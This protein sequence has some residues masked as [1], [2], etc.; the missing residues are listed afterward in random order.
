MTDKST[1]TPEEWKLLLES[2][3]MA[4]IA[5][6]P[7]EPSGLCGLLRES[8]ASGSALMQAKLDS[9][10]NPLIKA[11]VTDFETAEGQSAARDGMKEKLASVKPAEIKA[12]CIET[13]GQA[14]AVVDAKVLI[15][16]HRF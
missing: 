5:V 6:T 1:F 16:R 7:A 8:F 4:G 14:R 9:G 13:L 3:M 10:S 2:A 12:R 11:V 15:S